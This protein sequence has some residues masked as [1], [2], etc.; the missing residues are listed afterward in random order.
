MNNKNYRVLPKFNYHDALK[1]GL[2][3]VSLGTII[4]VAVR[5]LLP[6]DGQ[7]FICPELP[8][9][10]VPVLIGF[11]FW[12]V[13]LNMW[14]KQQEVLL[15]I[16]FFMVSSALTSGL[17]SGFGD[18]AAGRIFYIILVWL[19]PILLHAH[20]VWV[21]WTAGRMVR[22]TLL[23]FYGL[24]VAQSVP[25]IG[26]TLPELRFF[27]WFPSIQFTS[28]LTLIAAILVTATILAGYIRGC[29]IAN[30]CSRVR[31]VFFGLVLGLAPLTLLSILPSLFRLPF[32]PSIYNFPWLIFIPLSYSYVIYRHRFVQIEGYLSRTTVYYL[33]SVFLVSSYLVA[34]GI[35]ERFVPG[36][37][38][39]W[40][41]AGG[42][43]GAVIL[44]LVTPLRRI[45]RKWVTWFLYGNEKASLDMVSR[46]TNSLA[47][48]TDLETLCDQL[49]NKLSSFIAVQGS[50]LF[51]GNET[52]GFLLQGARGF[53]HWE[54]QAGII[55][56]DGKTPLIF[57][58]KSIAKPVETENIHQ[59]IKSMP[60]ISQ[61]LIAELPRTCLWLPLLSGDEMQGLMVLSPGSNNEYFTSEEQRVLSILARQ[62]GITAH[63]VQ[64]LDELR[65]GR[66]ELASAHR[67]LLLVQDEER[68]RLARELHD[69]DIQ[70]LLG[71]SYMVSD[72]KFELA[73]RQAYNFGDNVLV[74]KL[75]IA[76]NEIIGVVSQLRTIINELRPSGLFDV[77]YAKVLEQHVSDILRKQNNKLPKIALKLAE[78]DSDI[79]NEVT[80]CLFQ[81]TREA[82]CNALKHSLATYIFIEERVDENS[83]IVRIKDNGCGF[84][85]PTRLSEL[86]NKDH[87]GLIGIYEWVNSIG[88]QC[89]IQSKPGWGTEILVTI[90]LIQKRNNDDCK[91]F[92]GR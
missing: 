29:K 76:R 27:G 13:G 12:A 68:R 89:T 52:D 48:V 61:E 59:E 40:I 22:V 26:W 90:Q 58:L 62:A 6:C 66:E 74:E 91:N 73:K 34:Y 11:G 67:K 28:R 54:Q 20:L 77:G 86:A 50:L 80:S 72:I 21:K 33:T 88:G 30:I 51:L 46:M 23:I 31:M 43:L 3:L 83:V 19:A 75:E 32:I 45:F 64:L 71:I 4:W 55:Q 84:Q 18:D 65:N 14:F 47:L 37:R 5:L 70:Q 17:L 63:N 35:L 60:I 81:V 56:M 78:K 25:L 44:L 36:W 41:V 9:D 38:T 69:K 8:W 92:V 53:T 87:F 49:I 82:L 57:R 2:G 85:V 10:V 42:I 7:S 79:P 24:A 39:S 1:A 16:F 15:V